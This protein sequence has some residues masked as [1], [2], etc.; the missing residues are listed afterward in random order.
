MQR[1][2][3]V[4][5]SVTLSAS[6]ACW[7]VPR[8]DLTPVASSP[9]PSMQQYNAYVGKD[10]W[11]SGVGLRLCEGPTSA[12]C[13]EFLQLRT[14]LKVDGLVP[15]HSEVAGTSIDQPYFHVA[16]DDGR[17]GFADARIFPNFTTAVDPV[18]AVADCKRKGGPK[19][20]MNAAQVRATCWGRPSYVNAKTRS[21][22]RYEQYVYD[23]NKFVYF[24]NGIVTS[25]SV[26]GRRAVR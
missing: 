4:I 3:L 7:A 1:F 23:D 19:L 2:Y 8:V 12:R 10:Y 24:R 20:G 9:L 21:S 15:N 25:V 5:V 17:S 14:H 16:L 11:V 18:A 26:K 6:A 13:L 22:G